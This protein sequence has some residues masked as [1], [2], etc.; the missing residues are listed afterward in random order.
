MI[1]LGEIPI[2]PATVEG[3]KRGVV[4]WACNKKTEQGGPSIIVTTRVLREFGMR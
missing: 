2:P 3:L 1:D 4:H